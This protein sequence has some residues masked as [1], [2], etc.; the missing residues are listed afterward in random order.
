MVLSTKKEF[1]AVIDRNEY[2]PV[3]KPRVDGVTIDEDIY[4]EVFYTIQ[5][6]FFS[7]IMFQND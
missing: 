3:T 4:F 2:M 5:I 1:G 7:F 6:G